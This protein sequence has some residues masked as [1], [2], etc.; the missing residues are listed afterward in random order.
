M[1]SLERAANFLHLSLRALWQPVTF[2][3][4]CFVENEQGEVALVRHSYAGGWHLPG[5]GVDRHELSH[6]AAVREAQEEVGLKTSMPAEFFG[7]YTQRVGW[8]DNVIALYRLR[9]ASVTFE[10][11]LEIREMQWA[12]IKRPPQGTTVATARRLAELSGKK[13][14]SPVW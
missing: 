1:V 12:D 13:A 7:L 10:K 5:G 6:V 2:G 11:S 14:I 9:G 4:R 3:V 8:I